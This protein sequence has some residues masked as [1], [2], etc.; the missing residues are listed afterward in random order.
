MWLPEVQAEL[1]S[2][3]SGSR[4]PCQAS[5]QILKTEYNYHTVR[6]KHWHGSPGP[7]SVPIN[8]NILTPAKKAFRE[9]WLIQFTL[10][11]KSLGNRNTVST[12]WVKVQVHG[13]K[14]WKRACFLFCLT[15]IVWFLEIWKHTIKPIYKINPSKLP[16]T[17]TFAH[18]WLYVCVHKISYKLTCKHLYTTS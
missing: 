1:V 10:E 13:H 8:I 17:I 16:Y 18:M 4:V 7:T 9:A 12:L 14:N 3:M 5:E 2:W 6:P 11:K 15:V